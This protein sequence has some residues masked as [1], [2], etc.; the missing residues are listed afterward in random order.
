MARLICSKTKTEYLDIS[1]PIRIDSNLFKFDFFGEGKGF[2]REY[3]RSIK[4]LDILVMIEY[5]KESYG[6][7]RGVIMSHSL[8]LI[9]Y[10]KNCLIN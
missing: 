2:Y 8:D 9:K 1:R 7:T 10:A 6:I 5:N 4:D 3:Y